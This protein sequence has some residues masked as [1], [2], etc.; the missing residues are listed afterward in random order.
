MHRESQESY[1]INALSVGREMRARHLA[2]TL[3]NDGDGSPLPCSLGP[4]WI[5][6]A[7]KLTVQVPE[8]V[9]CGWEHYLENHLSSNLAG[10]LSEQV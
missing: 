5:P 1:E 3:V 9:A 6:S 2:V 7:L 10:I 4:G 8:T